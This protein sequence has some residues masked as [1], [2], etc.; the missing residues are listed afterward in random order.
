LNI[1]LLVLGIL[2]LIWNLFSLLRKIVY[3]RHVHKDLLQPLPGYHPKVG[4][5]VPCRGVDHGFEENM[6]ALLR[7]E[8]HDYHVVFVTGTADDPA[9]PVL[10]KI[11]KGTSARLVTSGPA[12]HCSQKIVNLLRG[13][14]EVDDDT[15]IL[16][17]ADSDGRPHRTWLRSLV[18]PLQDPKIGAATS[19]RWYLPVNGGFWSAVRSAWNA[20]STNPFYGGNST[21]VWGG[22]VALRKAVF[23]EI[24]ID[25]LWRKAVSDDLVLSQAMKNAG[26]RIAF[27]PQSLV[28]SYEDSSF[29]QLWEWTSRQMIIVKVYAPE[30]WK[31]AIYSYGFS[32][33]TLLLGLILC[34]RSL[35]GGNSP[36]LEGLLLLSHLP[37][38]MVNEYVRFLTYKEVMPAHRQKLQQYWWIYALLPPVASFLMGFNILKAATT[39]TINWRGIRY[40]LRSPTET[41]VLHQ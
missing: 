24:E 2:S 22:S 13:V 16:A 23:E 29:W 21:F 6:K 34:L 25:R 36:P 12:Q 40:E 28:V 1:F 38:G 7:Q 8:Y 3:R 31:M 30:V 5:I 11:L 41:I 17:F 26:Y 15:E 10:E 19:Y 18:Q 14:K 9:Y 4:L 33:V 37:L 39:N 27:V 20:A 32:N 35:G